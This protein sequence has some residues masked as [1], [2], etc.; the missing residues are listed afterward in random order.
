MRAFLLFLLFLA[1]LL[2]GRWYF[3]C[4][5]RQ[6]CAPQEREEVRLNTLLFR[7]G[8][9][10]V[11]RGYDHFKFE[12]GS[13]QPELNENNRAFLDEVAQY[14][15]G[16]PEKNLTIIGRYTEAED[17]IEIGIYENI[18]VARAEALR[19]ALARRG[20]DRDRISLDYQLDET[21]SLRRP[22]AFDAFLEDSSQYEK[23]AFTFTNMSFTDANFEF[24][25]AEFNPGPSCVTY[26]DSV[27]TYMTLNE[28]STL[29]IVGHTDSIDTDAFNY[30]LGLERA[31][32]TREYLTELGLPEERIEVASQGEQKPVA[33]N[34][35]DEGRQ[36]N[37]RV[38]FII[39]EDDE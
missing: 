28:E 34:R 6:M 27:E 16:K 15:L 4:Q 21:N 18:G 33:P 35:T 3:V 29:T 13:A 9:S 11:L 22:A 25:S 36:K 23:Q 30:R 12:P 5:V 10:I 19:K 7:D 8:D 37:R 26:M 2:L 31:K 14:L 24:G 20:V 38:V 32:S 17:T 1:F 39:N